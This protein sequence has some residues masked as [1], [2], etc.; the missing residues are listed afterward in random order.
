MNINIRNDYSSLFS[1]LSS[2]SSNVTSNFSLTDYAGIKNGSYSK[3]LK[4]YYAKTGSNAET[5]S[6]TSSVQGQAA[7]NTVTSRNIT[8]SSSS[9]I[10]SAEALITTGSDSLFAQKDMTTKDSSGKEVTQKG[11]DR[12]TIE[13]AVK[14]FVEDYN[15]LLDSAGE[16][17][18]KSISNSVSNLR[19]LTSAN[20][21]LLKDVGIS[22]GT[23]GTLSLKEDALASAD[24][25][26]LKSLFNTNSSYAYNVEAKASFIRMYAASDIGRS[27]GI[28]GNN[29]SYSSSLSSGS[30]LDEIV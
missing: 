5:G 10:E 9:L 22:I 8:N 15:A 23:D 26:T 18:N 30:L 12:K 2:G 14:S 29:A 13:K 4:A 20:S 28:Y 7:D 3:L 27:A 21:E 6:K 24:T 25:S 11:Y 17:K 16:S 1:S 19:S